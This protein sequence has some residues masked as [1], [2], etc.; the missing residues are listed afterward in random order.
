MAI[1]YPYIVDQ[2]LAEK[3]IARLAFIAEEYDWQASG[4]ECWIR[5]LWLWGRKNGWSVV[6]GY[7]EPQ[8][9]PEI[10]PLFVPSLA[11][12]RDHVQEEMKL[13][14]Y[15]SGGCASFW[16]DPQNHDNYD[17]LSGEY[18]SIVWRRPG[19]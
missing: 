11:I 9:Y 13:H 17:E 16:I 10:N 4:T 19:S 2:A 15:T 8:W 3:T 1:T 6:I 5:Y 14:I 18:Y 12:V 7:D